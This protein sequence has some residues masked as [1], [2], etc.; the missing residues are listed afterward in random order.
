ME[1]IS[2]S[3]RRGDVVE[4][5]HRVHAVLMRDGEVA[6]AWGDPALVTH[7]RSAAKPFQALGLARDARDLP[8]EEFAIACASHEALP[9]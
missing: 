5:R 9:E 8:T 7:M 1:A 4:S 6:E 2:V 3:V